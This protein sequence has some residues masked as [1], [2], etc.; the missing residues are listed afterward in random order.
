MTLGEKLRK[1]RTDSGLTQEEFAEKIYV[2]RTP[3]YD[4]L[5]ALCRRVCVRI[6]DN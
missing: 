5:T 1:L 3:P 2:T 4:K 6:I